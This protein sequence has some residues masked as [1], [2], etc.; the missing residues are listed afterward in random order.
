MFDP[1]PV[2]VKPKSLTDSLYYDTIDALYS[3]AFVKAKMCDGEHYQDVM[4]QLYC[5]ADEMCRK[6]EEG[7]STIINLYNTMHI[8]GDYVTYY[9]TAYDCI[10]EFNDEFIDE[11]FKEETP[12]KI[13]RELKDIG[14]ALGRIRFVAFSRA[15]GNKELMADDDL[16]GFIDD[17]DMA[18]SIVSVWEKRHGKDTDTGED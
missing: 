13:V 4:F 7:D 12:S 10:Y 17:I 18:Q 6:A 8:K 15:V 14:W 5:T 1:R 11:Y 2:R 9:G 16:S 3:E